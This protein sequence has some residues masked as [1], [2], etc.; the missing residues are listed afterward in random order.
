[1]SHDSLRGWERNVPHR[2]HRDG[3]NLHRA[4]ASETGDHHSERAKNLAD[5][6]CS[7][8]AEPL[9]NAAGESTRNYRRANADHEQRFA[10]A[11]RAPTETV[12]RE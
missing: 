11:A 7:F 10:N 2:N 8:F 5:I 9:H 4:G 12:N 3:R 1:M 6:K